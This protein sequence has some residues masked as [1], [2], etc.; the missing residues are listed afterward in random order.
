[1][2]LRARVLLHARRELHA[3]LS[4]LLRLRLELRQR[5]NRDQRVHLSGLTIANGNAG[6]IFNAG[7]LTVSGC[8]VPGNSAEFGGGISNVGTLTVS[9]CTLSANSA[10]FGGGIYNQGTLEVRLSGDMLDVRHEVVTVAVSRG[11]ATT[12]PAVL[13]AVSYR[14]VRRW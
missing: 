10:G 11:G 9:G 2:L 8:P 1:M 5:E 4:E 14:D 12:T 6:G 13:P 7:T 3:G